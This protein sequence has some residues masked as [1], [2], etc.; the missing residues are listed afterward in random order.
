MDIFLT[1]TFN[2]YGYIVAKRCRVV[3]NE[4]LTVGEK[5]VPQTKSTYDDKSNSGLPVFDKQ[6]S[7]NYIIF[8]FI[9]FSI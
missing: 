6:R 9:T 5:E 7:M 4:T 1:F 3:H 8:A 2:L